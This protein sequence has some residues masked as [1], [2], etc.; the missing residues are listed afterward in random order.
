MENKRKSRLGVLTMLIVFLTGCSGA[1]QD[2]ARIIQ[3]ELTASAPLSYADFTRSYSDQGVFKI[4]TSSLLYYLD[5]A[6]GMEFVVC[7]KPGCAHQDEDCYAYFPTSTY[8]SPFQD[9]LLAVT[10][11][12]QETSGEMFLYEMDTNGENRRKLAELGQ[13]QTIEMVQFTGDYVVIAYS[14]SWD[15]DYEQLE[16]AH[17]GIYVYD[18]KAGSGKEIWSREQSSALVSHIAVEGDVVYFNF[19]YCDLSIEEW[20]AAEDASDS[21]HIG[22]YQVSLDGTGEACICDKLDNAVPIVIMD[23]MLSYQTDEA[24]MQYDI[25]TGMTEKAGVSMSPVPCDVDG[26]RIY[27]LYNREDSR[28]GKSLYDYYVQRGDGELILLGEQ[29]DISV[30]LV[31]PR[32]SYAMY[33]GLPSGNGIQVYYKTEDLL[34]GRL[35]AFSTYLD[36]N[37]E[38]PYKIDQAVAYTYDPEKEVTVTGKIDDLDEVFA[39]VL[40]GFD[41]AAADIQDITIQRSVEAG[42]ELYSLNFHTDRYAYRYVVY[43]DAHDDVG[44]IRGSLQGDY[45]GTEHD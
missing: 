7:D 31:T 22:L 25:L 6:S 40:E 26:I 16:K 21:I 37:G 17:A 45:T 3:G 42:E 11:Y 4:G 27:C 36:I 19:A 30:E 43:Y 39:I 2:E 1:S 29:A 34:A 9:H 32:Y 28:M 24:L 44:K 12:G 13:M 14:N 23:G 35:D 41:E 38:E 5:G 20:L 15:E 8:V 18:L 33:Y 10:A